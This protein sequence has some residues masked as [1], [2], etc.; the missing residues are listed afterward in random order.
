MSASI[1]E[2]IW[3]P[4]LIAQARSGSV[5]YPKHQHI[6]TIR[7]QLSQ[8]LLEALCKKDCDSLHYA[9]SELNRM[10]SGGG[11]PVTDS[12][13]RSTAYMAHALGM[14]FL[15]QYEKYTSDHTRK[16]QYFT[17]VLEASSRLP[18]LDLFD[19]LRQLSAQYNFDCSA[20]SSLTPLEHQSA[21]KMVSVLASRNELNRIQ[22]FPE[23]MQWCKQTMETDDKTLESVVL[24]SAKHGAK[25]VFTW[26][27]EHA[28]PHIV[29]AAAD[30]CVASD[31]MQLFDHLFETYP[32][33]RRYMFSMWDYKDKTG[34]STKNLDHI[35]PYVQ[36][37]TTED[38]QHLCSNDYPPN[39]TRR[40][41]VAQ[42]A[43]NM[44]Q[45]ETIQKNI[46]LN[47]F[48]HTRRI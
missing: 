2:R 24:S 34:T 21:F 22:T 37:L 12:L 25:D 33:E 5:P 23:L 35:L 28:N 29:R 38:W 6:D 45:R 7:H 42:C 46:S 17:T 43:G 10:A 48:A 9:A 15:P 36:R 8:I 32:A 19:T 30:Q 11:S 16:T 13:V 20:P 47:H 1:I 26:A 39:T 40:A 31:Q 27:L 3:G 44:L 14:W 4:N 18:S 41:A